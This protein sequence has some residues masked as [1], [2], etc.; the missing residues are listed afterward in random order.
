MATDNP[1]SDPYADPYKQVDTSQIGAPGT[2]TGVTG[3]STAPATGWNK[4]QRDSFR[5]AWMSSAPGTNL[6]DFINTN[7]AASPW[8]SQ[9]S[10]DGDKVGLP[11]RTDDKYGDQGRE[12]L[13]LVKDAGPG[14][15]NTA[16]WTDYGGRGPTGAVAP[17]SGA[18][19]GNGSGGLAGLLGPGGSMSSAL[20]AQYSGGGVLDPRFNDL[21]NTLLS[22]SGQNIIPSA[23][24]PLIAAQTN[25]YSAQQTRGVRDYLAQQAE[26]Q[27]PNANLGAESRLANEHAA[28]ATG[29]MQ[30]SLMQN[31]LTARRAE[32]AQALSM[33]AGML[34]DQQR[35]ALQ[36]ELGLIDAN[37]HQQGINSGNDQ[38]AADYG[39]RNT[40][41]ANYW[42]WL[43]STGGN[44]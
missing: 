9:F 33:Q 10:V 26:Q 1:Y 20:L 8:A 13:D 22:R 36:Q 28:Q 14:G 34:S 37:L 19:A 11:T 5:D 21:Y 24:D 17:T 44:P 27:G 2:N 3:G 42:D 16:A 40:N 41:Q 35:I 43:R 31:E 18:P 6:Q 39:L 4:T 38:F 7:P 30:A 15:A 25:A 12:W 32:V 29:G 23:K